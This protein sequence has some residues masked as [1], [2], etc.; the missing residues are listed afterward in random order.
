MPKLSTDGADTPL[1]LEGYD[2]GDQRYELVDI[3][4]LQ[5]H[6]DNPN[7]GRDDVV[8]ESVEENGWYGAV[9]AQASTGHILVGNTRYRVL[10]AKGALQAPVIWKDVDDVTALRILLA[11]NETARKA[12][13]DVDKTAE[14]IRSLGSIRGTGILDLSEL[15]GD[16]RAE[17]EREADEEAGDGNGRDDEKMYDP[18][19][20]DGAFDRQYGVVV[21][22][23]DEDEQAEIYEEL[24]ASHP[25][26]QVR[27]VAV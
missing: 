10:R 25:E 11:D 27:V 21:V 3:D 5:E 12:E 24:R 17:E 14:I 19:D 6:P 13:I 1:D 22:C 23:R 18:D 20:A 2:L 4:R 8:A 9:I 7:R 26:L 15:E 16:E